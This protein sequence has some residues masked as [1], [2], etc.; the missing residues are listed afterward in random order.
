MDIDDLVILVGGRGTR[1][2]KIT[3]N[4]PKPLIKIDDKPFLDL[5]LS[6]LIKYNFKKIYLL[7]SYKKNI[8][9]QKYNN[10]KIHNSKIICIDEGKQK[11]TGGALFKLKKYL[12]KNFIMIN[13]DTF[14]DINLNILKNRNLKNNSIFVALSNTKKSKN[15]YLI[16][17]L[18]LKKNKVFFPKR[19]TNM[20]NGGIY[21]INKKILKK[22]QNKYL[23]FETNILYH[24]INKNKVEGEYFDADFIDIGSK[25]KLNYLKKNSKFLKNKCF[26]LD[27]D[28][29]INKDVGYLK[30]FKNF[31]FLKDVSKAIKFLNNKSYL[32]IIITNQAAVG[33]QIIS[34]NNLKFIH[35]K[36]KSVLYKKNNSYID[37]IYYAP[38]FKN[39]KILKYRK[40]S[41][42]RK[43]FP[44]MFK[45]AINKW[46]IDVK[47]S[48]FIGDQLSDMI[49]ASRV[50]IKFYY[51]KN[52]S[53]YDQIKNIVN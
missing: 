42:D 28:G 44:G 48:F 40:N 36:M 29:V 11:G 33:K 3:N 10:L 35:N 47:S 26:F 6:K 27:R 30:S 8:F 12:K 37:D 20:M 2:G 22:I 24:E 25:F 17:N 21:I 19:K 5:L 46:N 7:C 45:K 38:F 18:A 51:K 39:S 52:I 13:G 4:V 53:L 9:F 31:I 34:E 14:F 49:A 16:K 23:S 41:Y 43:P 32:V 1:L 15:N 50:N